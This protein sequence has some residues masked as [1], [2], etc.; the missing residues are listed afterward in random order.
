MIG[1]WTLSR[2]DAWPLNAKPRVGGET[3]GRER[4][5]SLQTRVDGTSTGFRQGHDREITGCATLLYPCYV[6]VISLLYRQE[7]VKAANAK[8]V[9]N[10]I[11]RKAWWEIGEWHW[12]SSPSG[13]G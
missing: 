9:E 11:A 5:E 6:P 8:G 7:T 4:S 2:A 3:L 1:S 13:A 12:I 10:Q